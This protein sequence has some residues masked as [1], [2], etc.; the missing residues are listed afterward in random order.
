MPG[1]VAGGERLS[2]P[3]FKSLI[4]IEQLKA[5]SKDMKSESPSLVLELWVRV[6]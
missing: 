3:P 2:W 4:S 1:L 6:G 5:R